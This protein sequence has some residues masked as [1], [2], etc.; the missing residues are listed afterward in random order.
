MEDKAMLKAKYYQNFK[1]HE[2]CILIIGE[3]NDYR[4]T[5][6]YFSTLEG[7]FLTPSE[8]IQLENANAAEENILLTK[9]ECIFF[10]EICLKLIAQNNAAHDYFDIESMPDTEFLIS[11]KEYSS[12]P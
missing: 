7:G 9:N 4:A 6:R 1:G 2:N 10:A 3:A 5:S 11:Y 8:F 12:L